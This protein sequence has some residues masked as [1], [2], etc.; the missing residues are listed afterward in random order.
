MVNDKSESVN[1]NISVNKQ[2]KL[3]DWTRNTKMMPRQ[4]NKHQFYGIV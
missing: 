4:N 1:P 2:P 3:V